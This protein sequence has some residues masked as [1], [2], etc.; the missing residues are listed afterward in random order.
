MRLKRML[1]NQIVNSDYFLT[2]THQSQLLYYHLCMRCDDRGYI[3]NAKTLLLQF[4]LP[5][6]CLQELIDKRFVL[7]R[8]NGLIL[9]KGWEIHADISNSRWFVE[10]KY[11]KDFENIEI[12]PNGAYTEKKEVGEGGKTYKKGGS[13]DDLCSTTMNV[14]KKKMLN[15][16]ENFIKEKENEETEV[17]I[18]WDNL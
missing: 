1:S 14:D 17:E 3:D 4:Q 12:E 8:T 6:T 9:I 13:G 16:K 2:L 18:D 7:L 15:R 11:L 5:D 10:T